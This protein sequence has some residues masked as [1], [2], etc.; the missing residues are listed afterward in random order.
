MTHSA[1]DAPLREIFS[2]MDAR[3]VHVLRPAYYEAMAALQVLANQL[4]MAEL[5]QPNPAGLLLKGHFIAC[6]ALGAMYK[7]RLGADL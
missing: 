2:S 5:N 1:T 6:Q 4:E 3:R 7:S